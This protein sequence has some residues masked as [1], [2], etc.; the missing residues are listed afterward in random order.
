MKGGGDGCERSV[1][2]DKGLRDGQA[3]RPLLLIPPLV[4]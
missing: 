1:R 3:V 4:A 2:R